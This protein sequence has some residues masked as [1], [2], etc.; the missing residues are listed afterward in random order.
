MRPRAVLVVTGTGTEVGKTWLSVEVIKGLQELEVSVA[1]R[2]PAQSFEPGNGKTD[3]DLLAAASGEPP[4]LVCPTHRW[5]PAP[6]APPMAA[7]SLGMS[8]PLVDDLLAETAASW[9]DL[10][11]DIGLV[12][13]AGGV[14]SPIATD[15]DTATLA[16]ALE[17]DMV[18]LV[19]EAG[20][21]TINCVRLSRRALEPLPV[22]VY[23]NRFDAGQE[24]HARNR[25]WLSEIDGLDLSWQR[26][27][28]VARLVARLVAPSGD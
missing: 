24:L 23:L 10:P 14:A 3:A 17:A 16:K 7:E 20:L 18:L 12:E 1:A 11:V 2:K 27:D 22:I 4:D 19:A 9:P 28:L 26:D 21:G 25:D 13:G 15:G 8:P 6:M 5:Y